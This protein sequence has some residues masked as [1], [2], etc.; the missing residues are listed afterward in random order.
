VELT[1]EAL[2]ANDG[3]CLLLHYGNALILIDG[4]S[5]GVY[6][7]VLKK[8]LDE[9]RGDGALALRMVMVSHIDADHI[10]GIQNLLDELVDEQNAG[11]ELPYR[12]KTIW[13]NS[14]EKLTGGR[15]ASVESAAVAA[16]VDGTPDE[17]FLASL[18]Y[19]VAAVV[20]S[21][22]QGNA[23]RND[24]V[25]LGIPINAGAGDDLV[26]AP[27]AGV[28]KI[29][30]VPGLTFTIL[31]PHDDELQKLDASWKASKE[32]EASPEAQAADYL[33]R[34]VPNLSSIVVLVEADLGAGK[35]KRLLLTG[36]AGGDRIEEALE[37]TGL[38][39]GGKLHVDLLKVQHHGSNHSVDLEFF[40]NITADHYVISGNGKHGI[41]HPDTLGW[42][43]EARRNTKCD[44]YLT[45][46]EGDLG[47]T[48]HLDDFLA[49]E[50][51]AGSK[52]RYHFR[53]DEALSIPVSLG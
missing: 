8:R 34:T 49:E 46:R 16:S 41:P 44:V 2:Q 35:K 15:K 3:D 22:K 37:K 26:R 36:D 29:Q 20:A 17:E 42:L 32:K 31:G 25:Q 47:L 52:I 24:A 21:V 53:E 6:Q 1:L 10:T 30:I 40:E 33:N 19:N 13:H 43:S 51:R 11:N 50:E 23:V 12:I 27:A 39:S 28:R 5:A 9:L 14:F 48:K 18:P 38:S 45:N 7:N 4:G